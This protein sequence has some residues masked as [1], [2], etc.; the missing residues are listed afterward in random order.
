MSVGWCVYYNVSGG[1]MCVCVSRV[2][3]VSHKDW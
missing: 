2:V 3:C 1:S